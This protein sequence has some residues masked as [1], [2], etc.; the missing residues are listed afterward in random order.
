VR[1]RL[2]RFA[3]VTAVVTALDV[4]LL[5]GLLRTGLGLPWAAAA[6]VAA[7]SGASW[8]LH[9]AVAAGDDPVARWLARPRWFAVTTVVAGGLDVLTVTL[10][11][12]P[13]R[14]GAGAVLVAKVVGLLLAGT[15]RLVA[16]RLVSLEAT[17]TTLGRRHDRS[18]PPGDVRLTVVVPAYGEAH[19]IGATVA[20]LDATLAG[21]AASGGLEVLVVDD[22]STDRTSEV[23]RTAGARVLR[24][25]ENRGKGAAVRAGMLAAEGRTVAFLDADLAY[26]PEQLLALLTAVEDGWDVAVGS[27]RHPASE[28]TVHVDPLRSVSGR[29]FN[30][31]TAIVLLG[32]HRDTQCGCK[33][34]RSDAARLVFARTRLDG[35]AFD[36]E[37]FHLVERY[38][39]SLVEVPVTLQEA[40]GSTVRV[41]VDALA[42]LRD[43][44]RVR[45]WAGRG[46]YDLP[47]DAVPHGPRVHGPPH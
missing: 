10:L 19:R 23:A 44:F 2:R 37:V 35:F 43:L 34:F 14:P 46:R 31:L 9:R 22:G 1:Q 6:A 29:L 3:A 40:E 28:A 12:G 18:A 8:T 4:A 13:G 15:V 16:H 17:R 36:V 27:R 24:L 45:R 11:A 32:R 25:P 42:M 7:A 41:G 26:P 21:V 5:L 33:A 38:R 47:A 20:A 30:L 39:L